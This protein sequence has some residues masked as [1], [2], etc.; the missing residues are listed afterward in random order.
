MSSKRIQYVFGVC[1]KLKANILDD[2]SKGI[3]RTVDEIDFLTRI[4]F[5]DVAKMNGVT[6]STVRDACTRRMNLNAEGFYNA[7]KKRLI[8]GKED[9]FLIGRMETCMTNEDTIWEI[10]KLMETIF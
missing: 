3:V 1:A 2:I 10:E 8:D 4:A 9:M 6:E 7:V 5:K